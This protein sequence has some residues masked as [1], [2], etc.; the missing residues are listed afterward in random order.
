[1]GDN[2]NDSRDG[3]GNDD[4]NAAAFRFSQKLAIKSCATVE[5]IVEDVC[6]RIEWSQ[7]NTNRIILSLTDPHS[8]M[9]DGGRTTIHLPKVH[10]GPLYIWPAC[11]KPSSGFEDFGKENNEIAVENA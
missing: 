2:R 11:N 6:R 7:G 5:V 8:L 4:S 3:V 9:A 1:M 10:A